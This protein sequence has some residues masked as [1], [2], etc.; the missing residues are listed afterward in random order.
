MKAKK[1]QSMD[2]ATAKE[3]ARMGI[4]TATEAARAIDAWRIEGNWYP[5][6]NRTPIKTKCGR[7][8]IP[9]YQPRSGRESY[10]DI[11]TNLNVPPG[12]LGL[13]LRNS[14]DIVR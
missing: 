10:R 13:W 4:M 3:N 11:L 1:V 14:L 9:V 6:P 8:L 2:P 12:L 5:I 7:N